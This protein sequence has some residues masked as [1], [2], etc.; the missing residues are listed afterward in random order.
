METIANPFASPQAKQVDGVLEVAPEFGH[1]AERESRFWAA[2]IDGAL[3]WVLNVVLGL[4]LAN[5]LYPNMW[6]FYRNQDFQSKSTAELR[7][8]YQATQPGWEFKIGMVFVG[9]AVF[10]AING[11]LLATKGQT[12]GKKML[13]IK[14]VRTN[15]TQ[16]GIWR[17]VGLRYLPFTLMYLIPVVGPIVTRLIDPLMIFDKSHK[18]MHDEFA[19]TIVIRT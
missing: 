15:G 6:D 14:I 12:I 5:S 13:G 16:A 1:F 7:R 3:L 19:D 2:L 10:L 18:C 11:Y 4:V 9:F 17:L 8:E